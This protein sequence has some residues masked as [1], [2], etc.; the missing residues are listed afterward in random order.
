MATPTFVSNHTASAVVKYFVPKINTQFGGTYTFATGRT[1]YNPNS[2]GFLTDRAS[3]YNDLS[4]NISYLTHLWDQFTIV[5]FSVSNVFGAENVFGYNYSLKPNSNGV[6]DA[7]AV[8]PGARRFWFLGVFISLN[9][10]Q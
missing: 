6:Y 10:K 9:V 2:E 3:N 4:L 1:Y 5:Y 8:E 7:V